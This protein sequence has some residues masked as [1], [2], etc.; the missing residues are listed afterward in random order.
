MQTFFASLKLTKIAAS[1]ISL[2]KV[3]WIFFFNFWKLHKGVDSATYMKQENQYIHHKNHVFIVGNF[4]FEYALIG[5][6]KI[7]RKK[8]L[9]A[10][11][12]LYYKASHSPFNF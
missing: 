6:L 2:G 4:K 8:L 3:L 1:I 7:I 9:K 5:F 12:I 10:K 11:P